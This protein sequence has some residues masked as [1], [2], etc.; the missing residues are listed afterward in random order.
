MNLET[1]SRLHLGLLRVHES[2]RRLA[3]EQ[4]M[5][6]GQVRRLLH[7][8]HGGKEETGSIA[9]PRTGSE[10]GGYNCAASAGLWQPPTASPDPKSSG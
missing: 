1:F 6:P 4:A 3:P 5:L 8:G 2:C 9:L 7:E 10:P